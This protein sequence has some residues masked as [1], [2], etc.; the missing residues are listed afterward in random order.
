M[1]NTET[2]HA[3]HDSISRLTDIYADIRFREGSSSIMVSWQ[4]KIP[5]EVTTSKIEE[6]LKQ[7][8]NPLPNHCCESNFVSFMILR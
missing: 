3:I 8:G 2:F 7:F 4:G 5:D 6:A 1:N